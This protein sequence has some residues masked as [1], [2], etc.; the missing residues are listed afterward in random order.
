LLPGVQVWIDGDGKARS[1]GW[2]LEDAL[3]YAEGHWLVEHQANDPGHAAVQKWAE[4]ADCQTEPERKKMRDAQHWHQRMVVAGHRLLKNGLTHDEVVGAL[5]FCRKPG[6][7]DE[8]WGEVV[9][10]AL[11]ELIGRG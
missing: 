7:N 3:A 2:T 10:R 8:E 5:H 1:R 6:F 4:L 11:V 9:T